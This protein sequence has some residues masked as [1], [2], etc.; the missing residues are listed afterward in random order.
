MHAMSWLR[1]GDINKGHVG[2]SR[3]RRRRSW[4]T[5]PDLWMAKINKAG[6]Q[7]E[8]GVEDAFPAVLQPIL[9]KNEISRQRRSNGEFHVDRE[10]AIKTGK[11][12]QARSNKADSRNCRGQDPV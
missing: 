1:I 8:T 7:V 10:D 4:G 6:G 5:V 11:S 3:V 12:K 2:M 9:A